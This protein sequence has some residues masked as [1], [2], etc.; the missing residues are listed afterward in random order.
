MPNSEYTFKLDKSPH[1][2]EHALHCLSMRPD[3]F[4][5][6]GTRVRVDTPNQVKRTIQESQEVLFILSYEDNKLAN[7]VFIVKE[8]TDSCVHVL[9]G[10]SA[11]QGGSL[12][13]VYGTI[14]LDLLRF[15]ARE[16]YT[17][18]DTNCL[19]GHSAH[20]LYEYYSK[21]FTEYSFSFKHS[22]DASLVN[23]VIDLV[24]TKDSP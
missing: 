12:S 2:R 16:G 9:H 7:N 21:T 14:F 1:A 23:L 11:P 15:L 4:V 13:Y 19:V 8:T 20:R 17:T 24:N 5:E 22:S 6:Y 10:I 18:Y 3:D